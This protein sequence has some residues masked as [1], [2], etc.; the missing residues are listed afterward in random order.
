MFRTSFCSGE[1][2]VVGEGVRQLIL[3]P[4]VVELVREETSGLGQSPTEL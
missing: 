1:Q 4:S 3:L 2:R